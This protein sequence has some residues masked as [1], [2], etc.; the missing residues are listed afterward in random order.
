MYKHKGMQGVPKHMPKIFYFHH[1]FQISALITDIGVKKTFLLKLFRDFRRFKSY[2]S[3]RLCQVV[4][5][6]FIWNT[7]L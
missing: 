1:N 6:I 3:I 7:E 4:L 5:E 2:L